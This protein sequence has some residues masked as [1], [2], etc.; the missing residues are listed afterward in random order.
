MASIAQKH[1]VLTREFLETIPHVPGV[2]LMEDR[3]KK[4]IYVGK[5]RDLRKRLASYARF[6]GAEHSKT[7]AMVSRIASI[8][9]ILTRTEKEAL[10]LESSL[11]KKHKPKYNVILRDDKSYPYI[12]VTV[13]ETWPRVLM[14]RRKAKDGARYF[15]PYSSVGAMWA[16]LKLIGDMFPLRRCKGRELRPRSRPCLNYQMKGCLAPCAGKADPNVY[17]GMVKDVLALLEGRNRELSTRIEEKMNRAVTELRFE[18]AAIYRDQL[19]ALAATLEKQVVAGSRFGEM[20]VFGFA[21]TGPSV[22]ATILSVR[23]GA[24]LGHRSYF[25]AEPLGEDDEVLA[26]IIKRYYGESE[27]IPRELVVPFLPE[28]H[29]L[30]ADWLA[31]CRQT[32][33]AV[34]AP[35]RGDL[36]RLLEMARANADQVFA[37]REKQERTWEVLA[38][39]LMKV[40][41][42]GRRPERI[43]CLDIS[44]LGGG[45]AVGSLVCF[46]KGLKSAGRYRHYRIRTVSGP[47]DYKMMA[48]VLERRLARGL[49]E[50]DLPDL[51]LL[52]GGKGQ[53]AVGVKV[54]A[55]LGISDRLEFA[56]IAK[57]KK[58]EGEKLFRPGRKNPILLDR[59]SRL[60]LFLMKVRDESHRYGITFHRRLRRKKALASELDDIPGVGP[61]RKKM[62][63][64]SLGSLARVKGASV[65]ELLRVPGIGPE[66]ARTIHNRLRGGE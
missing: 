19:Q 16:T 22:A 1:K 31:D 17:Q 44:N 62:L 40:L 28:D 35:R 48:E 43:E 53:L 2:Y 20:D 18:D 37:D 11:I 56:A 54:A 42:L 12:K 38:R 5:A 33:V 3:E 24:V 10:I 65:E 14:T 26:E 61:D 4:I 57:E 50:D 47:D 59:H 55:E 25:L 46:E 52:D 60:L 15:G 8:E 45:E 7:A 64:K 58:E 30:L 51:L 27:D 39:S 63:L 32:R 21:R 49:E 34:R 9:T 36:L 66:L 41:V 6:Q 29:E 23:H 13:N